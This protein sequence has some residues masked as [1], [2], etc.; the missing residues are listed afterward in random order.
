LHIPKFRLGRIVSGFRRRN[1]PKNQ[2]STGSIQTASKTTAP[3]PVIELWKSVHVVGNKVN[4]VAEFLVDF[5]S[6]PVYR[7]HA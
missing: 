3:F 1:D 7:N 5:K 2:G 4:K 6:Q